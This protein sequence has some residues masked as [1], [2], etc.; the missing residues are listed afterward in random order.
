MNKYK[1]YIVLTAATVILHN[2]H[3][4]RNPGGCLSVTSRN[5]ILFL[6]YLNSE[7]NNNW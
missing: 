1:I 7:R 3:M 6:Q 4:V 2:F 5:L